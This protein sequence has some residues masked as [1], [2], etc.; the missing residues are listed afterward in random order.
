MVADS[1]FQLSTIY[2]HSAHNSRISRDF[3]NLGRLENCQD[4]PRAGRSMAE[5]IRKKVAKVANRFEAAAYKGHDRTAG[6]I[7][8]VGMLGASHVL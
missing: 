1:G 6:P 8:S 5:R 3:L 2:P 4:E 7:E